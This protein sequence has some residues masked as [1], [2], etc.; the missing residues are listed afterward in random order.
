MRVFILANRCSPK[1][2][3]FPVHSYENNSRNFTKDKNGVKFN[4]V[5]PYCG[6]DDHLITNWQNCS[7]YREDFNI[8][9]LV[10]IKTSEDKTVILLGKSACGKD[11]ILN[12]LKDNF[13]FN[14]I[15]SHT[16]RPIRKNEVNGKDYYF[17][18]TKEFSKMLLQEEFIETRE[19]NT[20]FNGK[21]DIWYYGIAK[22]EFD[23]KKKKICV[24]D[25]TGQKEIIKYCGQENVISIYIDVDDNIREE[26]AKS[27]GS[28]SQS[29][30]DRRLK[31][32]NKKFKKVKYNYIL[33]NNGDKE[34]YQKDIENILRKENLIG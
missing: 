13:G 9:E 24:V 10:N 27:R 17:V 18:N 31:D 2:I 8:K 5:K 32:D 7:N 19:Y 30:W 26:R 11:H 15:I 20:C 25:T 6:F 28:F 29:E 4:S 22:Q 3:F 34:Q 21:P 14:S 12:Y 16:T 33:K 1:C 23:N